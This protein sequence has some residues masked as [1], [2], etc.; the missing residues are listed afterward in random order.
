VRVNITVKP[1]VKEWDGL[2]KANKNK[3]LLASWNYYQGELMKLIGYDGREE[4][5]F[6]DSV[7]VGSIT[8]N[9]IINKLPT[10][11]AVKMIEMLEKS[12]SKG[13]KALKLITY[14]KESS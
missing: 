10:E 3:N 1:T 12:L 2:T 4:M 13:S 5:V 6:V 9:L 14:S 7:A 11:N 8:Y